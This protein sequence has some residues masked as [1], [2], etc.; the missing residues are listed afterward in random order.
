[1]T[2][3]TVIFLL[4]AG[5]TLG[6]VYLLMAMGLTLV[7]GVTKVFN[8]AQGSFFTWG[9]YI[10]WSLS[11]GFLHW[12][13]YVVIPITILIMFFLGIIFQNLIVLPLRRHPGWDF[14]VIIVTLGCALVLDNLALVAFGP[15]SKTLPPLTEGNITIGKFAIAQHDLIMLGVSLAVLG[16]LGLFL[17]KTRIGMALRAVSQDN[18]GARIVGLPLNLLYCYAFGIST[19]LAGIAAILLAPRTLLYPQVGWTTL[20]KSFVVMVLGGLGNIKGT[21]VAAF[22]LS[23]AE[24]FTSFLFGGIWALP[25][26]LLVLIVILVFRPKGLFGQW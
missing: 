11:A 26:F 25:I 4:I 15:L 20:L 12:N 23:I 21:V 8:Y 7:Y 5:I 10:A 24:V 2:L 14:T 22:I 19:I 9:G 18:M 6:A 1:M 17:S 16:I 3:D 13:Y